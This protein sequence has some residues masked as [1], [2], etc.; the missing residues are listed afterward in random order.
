[1]D[2]VEAT[3]KTIESAMDG[4][5]WSEWNFTSMR[6]KEGSSENT[7]T[8]NKWGLDLSITKQLYTI[9]HKRNDFL[10]SSKYIEEG[11]SSSRIFS[12]DF[13][14]GITSFLL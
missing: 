14:L 6:K 12:G 1:M 8:N 5:R 13:F 9:S 2:T 3:P 7:S 4:V 11:L 10:L